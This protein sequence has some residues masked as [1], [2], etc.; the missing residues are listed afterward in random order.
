VF[1][2][3]ALYQLT[4]RD[5]GSNPESKSSPDKE[6]KE[7]ESDGM[8]LSGIRKR[9]ESLGGNVVFRNTNGFEV[10]VSVPKERK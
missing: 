7:D 10:F 3:P 9:V 6:F 2:H 4:I 5:N 1:E 8:G